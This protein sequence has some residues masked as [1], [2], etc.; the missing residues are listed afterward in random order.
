MISRSKTLAL[1]LVSLFLTL[2]LLIP[3]MADSQ[4][5]S[6]YVS[7]EGEMGTHYS[8]TMYSPNNQTT[9]ANTM[10]VNFSLQWMYDIMPIGSYQLRFEYAYSIDD[11]P[12]VKIT[13]NQTS[14]DRYAGGT[15]LT[16]NPSF[17]YLLNISNLTDGYHKI[18]IKPSFF[19]AWSYSVPSDPVFFSVQN[20]PTP[21]PTQ[22]P[23]P[24]P[25]STLAPTSTP[26]VPEF[27]WLAILPLFVS[28][29]LIAVVLRYR[30]SI[31]LKKQTAY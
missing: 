20:S 10:R 12:F 26:T 22:N 4:T 14:T 2:A 31:N 15:N 17:S 29:L 3:S 24:T 25:T 21:T 27:S 13:P 28:L 5:P 30:K 6:S 1:V 8:L 11:N 18:Q 7:P 9:Y 19:F 23:T 16:T